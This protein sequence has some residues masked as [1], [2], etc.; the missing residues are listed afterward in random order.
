MNASVSVAPRAHTILLGWGNRL[1]GILIALITTPLLLKA[2]GADRYSA[3]QI[4]QSLGSWLGLATL[5]VGPALKNAIASA[6]AQ[7]RD[8]APVR[9]AAGRVLAGVTLLGGLGIFAIGPF[10]ANSVFG[11]LSLEHSVAA[12]AVQVGGSLLLLTAVGHVGHEALFGGLR[13]PVSYA[14][15]ISSQFLRLGLIL[16]VARFAPPQHALVLFIAAYL[17]PGALLGLSAL[18]VAKI[19]PTQRV[20]RDSLRRLLRQ[21]RP[22]LTNSTL[23]AAVNNVDYLIMS[24]VLS[25][26]SI[27]TYAVLM[28]IVNVLLTAMGTILAVEWPIWTMGFAAGRYS[29]IKMSVSRVAGYGAV[30][31][32]IASVAA[33]EALPWILTIWLGPKTIGYVPRPTIALFLSYLTIRVWTDT[34]TAGLHALGRA[35]WTAGVA[36]MQ[37]TITGPAEYLLGARFGVDGVVLGLIAGQLCT[38]AWMNPW[39]FVR[40]CST[41]TRA[42][43]QRVPETAA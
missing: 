7:A 38:A 8:D 19:R 26:T 3:F 16:V 32:V 25:G 17:G 27:A 40:A 35:G 20:D 28:M 6:T 24:R 29:A 11:R 2:L 42:G 31:S 5:G 43:D 41:E 15:W 39:R 14:I 23:A 4:V 33:G 21:G 30:I 9:A 18:G 34:F 10:A 13:A 37:A 1:I 36:L 12:L 22:F